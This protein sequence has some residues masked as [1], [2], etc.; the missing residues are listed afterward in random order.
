MNI[1]WAVV[2][3]GTL[4]GC[5]YETVSSF[6]TLEDLRKS[7]YRVEKVSPQPLDAVTACMAMALRGHTTA[8]NHHPHAA[9][10]VETSEL[11]HTIALKTPGPRSGGRYPDEGALLYLIEN[12][13]NETQ[14][15]TFYL[16]VNPRI[17]SPGPTQVLTDV[18]AL[19]QPCL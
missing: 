14:G 19:V 15:M 12:R 9:V 7:D 1:R 10:Q 4:S 6:H 5:A 16:W 11:I 13:A 2:V 3:L 18:A 17:E 8:G